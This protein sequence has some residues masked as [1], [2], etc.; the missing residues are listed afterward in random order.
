MI[1]DVAQRN[2]S[3]LSNIGQGRRLHALLMKQVFGSLNEAVPFP[4]GCLGCHLFF[5]KSELVI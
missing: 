5:L 4:F 3:K 1:V 2:V